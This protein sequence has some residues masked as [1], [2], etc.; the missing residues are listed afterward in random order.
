MAGCA[1]GV[2][3]EVLESLPHGHAGADALGDFPA[4]ICPCV[5]HTAE[6]YGVRGLGV[7]WSS[8][9]WMKLTDFFLKTSK[10]R[11]VGG[12]VSALT[13]RGEGHQ[14]GRRCVLVF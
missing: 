1:G 4:G 6:V 14:V 8:V 11:R 10:S 2:F 5:E 13:L 7:Q 3:P 9:V 12:A